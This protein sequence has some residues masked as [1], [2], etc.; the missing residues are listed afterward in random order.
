MSRNAENNTEELTTVT[1]EKEVKPKETVVLS[2]T[3][4]ADKKIS[5]A[6]Y[7]QIKPQSSNVSVLLKKLYS[8]EFHT[9]SEWDAIVENLLATKIK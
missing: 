6:K 4:A 1:L 3:V 9:E 8:K 7:L 2:S 5:V